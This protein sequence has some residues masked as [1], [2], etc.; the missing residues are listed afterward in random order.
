M[1]C[2]IHNLTVGTAFLHNYY[3]NLNTAQPKSTYWSM[4]VK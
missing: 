4:I 2:I 3:N 1:V